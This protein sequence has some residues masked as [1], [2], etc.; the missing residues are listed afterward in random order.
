MGDTPADPV[1]CLL[2]GAI[3]DALGAPVEFL[4]LSEIR[5]RYGPR[6]VTEYERA[7]GRRGAITDD[8]QMTLFTTEGLIRAHNRR[9]TTG[10][11]DWIGSLHRAYL[12]W[13]ETQRDAWRAFSSARP[14]RSGWLLEQ[15]VLHQV[16]APGNTC[17]SALGVGRPGTPD[18]RINHSK[19]CGGV[20]RVAPIGF[21]AEEPFRGAA[22]A[23]AI[24]HGHP[25]GFLSAG[26]FASI[27]A[28][29]DRGLALRESAEASLEEL[30][31]W[32][33]HEETT[34]AVRRALELASGADAVPG[35]VERLGGG[36][37]GEEAL[38]IALFCAL[39]AP[40]FRSGVLLA[41]NHG[42][43]SD[44]TAAIAGNLLGAIHGRDG[45]PD[46]LLD[47]LEAR[48]LIERVAMDLKRVM[49]SRGAPV[50]PERYPPD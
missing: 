5:E 31:G 25:S 14:E 35:T 11:A 16:R 29:L 37:V 32:P 7:Y 9:V 13:Y 26:T 28:G 50:D 40:D 46:D 12:R 1:G 43:D 17:L 47:G 19:G 2:G 41:A 39:T 45:L 33:E 6:G 34:A 42:G 20:M 8:T 18:D 44:S 10:D 21:L 4:S 22:E 23:A 30:A 48:E 27:L 38:A 15:S 24:T 36:W 3:G 49:E